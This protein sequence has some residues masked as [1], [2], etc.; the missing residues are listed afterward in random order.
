MTM[1]RDANDPERTP[2]LGVAG[3]IVAMAIL[4]VGNGLMFAYVPVRLSA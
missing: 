3:V 2:I 1:S 4:A